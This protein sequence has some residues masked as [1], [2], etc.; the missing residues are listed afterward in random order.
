M[1]SNTDTTKNR[2]QN[3]TPTNGKLLLPPTRHPLFI[4]RCRENLALQLGV[5]VR[6]HI[7]GLL[8]EVNGISHSAT[9]TP[10]FAIHIILGIINNNWWIR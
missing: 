4:D 6:I 1:M 8:L 3:Q 2:G 10:L 9:Y 5:E 7:S